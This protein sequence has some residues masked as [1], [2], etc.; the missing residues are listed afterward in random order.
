[1]KRERK[2]EAICKKVFETCRED[3]GDIGSETKEK[4]EN[5]EIRRALSGSLLTNT[6]PY[7]A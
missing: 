2:R 6:A 5:D 1:M 4:D 7:A 3:R